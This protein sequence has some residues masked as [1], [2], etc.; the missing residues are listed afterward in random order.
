MNPA[1]TSASGISLGIATALAEAGA[2]VV[3]ADIEKD[4]ATWPSIIVAGGPEDQ[5]NNER[6]YALFRSS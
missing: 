3:M 4:E 1:S 5:A 2:N 6:P